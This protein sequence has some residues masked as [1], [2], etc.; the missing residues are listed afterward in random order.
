MLARQDPPFREEAAQRLSVKLR[1]QE[2]RS[3]K[4]DGVL[5]RAFIR[6]PT[7]AAFAL[8]TI[9]KGKRMRGFLRRRSLLV[10]WLI[11]RRRY[12]VSFSCTVQAILL[13]L[14]TPRKR[15]SLPPSPA[16]VTNN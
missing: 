2:P 6:L 4:L 13:C 15:P 7:S 11:K 3:L 8:F 10:T 14:L 9:R 1:T 12:P 5:V 16:V